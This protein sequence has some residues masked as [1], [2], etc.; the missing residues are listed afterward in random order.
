MRKYIDIIT[1]YY[2]LLLQERER[3]VEI[4]E[5]TGKILYASV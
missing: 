5:I 3:T 4:V 2:L 1:V